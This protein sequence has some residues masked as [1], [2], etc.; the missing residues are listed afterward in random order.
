MF[1][2]KKSGEDRVESSPIDAV[3]ASTTLLDRVLTFLLTIALMLWLVG[4]SL[5]VLLLPQFTGFWSERLSDYENSSVSPHELQSAADSGVRYVSGGAD[6]MPRSDNE[7]V[8]FTAEVISHMRDV[9]VVIS[10]IRGLTIAIT[11]IVTVIIALLVKRGQLARIGTS[12]FISSL[13]TLGA[14]ATLTLFGWLNF[15]ALFHLMHQ[16]LFA[17]GT[18][19]FSYNSLLITAYPLPFWIA[20]AATWAGLLLIGCIA[21]LVIGISI[22]RIK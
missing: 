19:Q 10:T 13:L 18:W 4:A 20:M 9:R 3:P 5:M 15:D 7:K 6:R 11:V 2:P 22:K 8:G 1:K 12:C 16:L 17:E 14:V 21:T